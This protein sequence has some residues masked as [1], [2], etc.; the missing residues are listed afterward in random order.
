MLWSTLWLWTGGLAAAVTFAFRAVHSRRQHA[1]PC[2]HL[3]EVDVRLPPHLGG[4]KV[5]TWCPDCQRRTYMAAW[6]SRGE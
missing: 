6:V 3:G 4:S 5:A 2:L 1:R